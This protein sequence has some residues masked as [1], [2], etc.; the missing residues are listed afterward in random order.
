[1]LVNCSR[2]SKEFERVASAIGKRVFCSL[3]CRK[4]PL[5]RICEGCGQAYKAH[6]A[7]RK[8]SRFCSKS[9][10]KSGERHHFYG[11]EGPTK[12]QPT[13]IKGLTKD[14][15]PRVASMAFKVSQT[16]KQQFAE[17]I[18]SNK[19]TQNP[20]WK[21]PEERKTLLNTAIRQTEQYAQWRLAVFQRDGFKCVQCGINGTINADHIVPFAVILA[22]HQIRSV[23]EALACG[24][25]WDTNNGRTL[26]VGCHRQTATY[27]CGTIKPLKEAHGNP[28]DQSG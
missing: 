2:C 25:L 23:E 8:T 16:H 21:L 12:G 18:R 20:N 10:A 15:D 26:C 11:K 19:G 27:G 3:A 7:H 6:I 13:W 22:A 4:E 9:C 17:G 14:S 1:M 5:D 24:P 28:E